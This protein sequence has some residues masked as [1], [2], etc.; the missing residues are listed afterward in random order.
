MRRILASDVTLRLAAAAGYVARCATKYGASAPGVGGAGCVVYGLGSAWA[1][2][3]WLAAGGFL[4]MLD[5]RLA[6]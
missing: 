2:L 4:L 1:P 6:A 5:R 3:G